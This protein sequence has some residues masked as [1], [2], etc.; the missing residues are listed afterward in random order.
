MHRVNRTFNNILLLLII[1]TVCYADINSSYHLSLGNY[2]WAFRSRYIVSINENI[3]IFQNYIFK[4]SNHPLE[5]QLPSRYKLGNKTFINEEGYIQFNKNEIEVNLGKKYSSIGPSNLSGLLISPLSPPLDQFSIIIKELGRLRFSKHIIRLDNRSIE[6]NGTNEMVHRWLYINTIGIKSKNGD[7]KLNFVDAVISTGFNRN[8]EW[9]YLSPLPNLIL[10]RK[11]QEAWVEGSD[12]LSKIGQGDNDNHLLGINSVYRYENF[13]FYSELLIDEWQLS[14]T[15]RPHMQTVFG[16]IA[17]LV[18]QI[19]NLDISLEYNL[20][21]P[22]LY[23]NRGIYSNLELQGLPIGL[24]RPNS[25][26]FSF[27][28]KLNLTNQRHLEFELYSIEHGSQSLNTKWNAWDNYIDPSKFVKKSKPQLKF[29]FYNGQNKLIDKVY[30]YNNW[31]A[32]GTFNLILSK[33]WKF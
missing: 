22:W 25:Q 8:L 33:N 4:T 18:Y 26:G 13:K 14:K 1:N 10:E 24:K 16:F 30:L 6:W 23:L 15:A 11:H 32:D 27:E 12:S 9:Y 17:G 21:S 19:D 2:S 20:A 3:N 28:L 31:F 7:F 5:R 29:V